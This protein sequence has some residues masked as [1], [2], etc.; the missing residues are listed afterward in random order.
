MV[1]ANPSDLGHGKKVLQLFVNQTSGPFCSRP[2]QMQL[3]PKKNHKIVQWLFIY[4]A[5]KHVGEGVSPV[6]LFFEFS[7]IEEKG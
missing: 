4:G 6:C 1:M 2:S 7:E 5:R 3:N